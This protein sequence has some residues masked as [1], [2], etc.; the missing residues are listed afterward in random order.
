MS[1][2]NAQ[3]KNKAINA[4]ISLGKNKNKKLL[5]KIKGFCVSYTDNVWAQPI[6]KRKAYMK[7]GSLA[8]GMIQD[9]LLVDNEYIWYCQVCQYPNDSNEMCCEICKADK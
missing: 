8:N 7:N 3:N 1:K 2:E 5:Q 4:S 6:K 9:K